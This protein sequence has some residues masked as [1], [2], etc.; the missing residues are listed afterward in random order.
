[1][2]YAGYHEVGWLMYLEYGLW[3]RLAVTV[4]FPLL[5]AYL[6]KDPKTGH[7][8][9]HVASGDPALGLKWQALSRGRFTLGPEVSVRFPLAPDGEVATVFG[10]EP[11]DPPAGK[12]Q[13]GTGVWDIAA[14]VSAGYG[15]DSFYLA[16]GVAYIIRTGGYDHDL[17]WTAEAGLPFLGRFDARARL[18]G[19]HPLPVGDEDM[20]RHTSPSGVGNGTSYVGLALEGEARVSRSWRLGLSA[21]GGLFAVQ[22]QSRGP[23]ISVY[24]A[25]NF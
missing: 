6:L 10:P 1:M 19:R 15:A 16:A 8:N 22:R 20:P 9:S 2:D 3:R 21:E 4:H 17:T 18:S 25:A 23:V 13:V 11:G 5:Q 7:Y 14:G 12:L 24:G